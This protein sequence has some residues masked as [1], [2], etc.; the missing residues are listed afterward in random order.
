MTNR[1]WRALETYG[2]DSKITA[3][4]FR[5]YKFDLSYSTHSDVVQLVDQVIAIDAAKFGDGDDLRQ[6]Q[7]I[8]KRWDHRTNI[9]NR[10]AA[11]AVL[12]GEP[13]LHARTIV[14]GKPQ[15]PTEGQMISALREAM[16][17]LKDHFGRLDP[18]WG[19]V[20]RLRRGKLDLAID[21]GPDIYR[22]VYG[23]PQP[24]GTLT[25]AG[26]DTF[27]MFVTW[28]KKGILAS[29]SIHQ[30]GS[31]TLDQ[32]SPH[33]AD[34]SPLFVAMKTKPVLFTLTELSG[35]VEA[36]YQ[37]GERGTVAVLKH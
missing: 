34:Q 26:G 37:P 13:A 30:F 24:D 6:A 5:A 32:S 11:L 29:E 31:A 19:E 14:N 22:A 9:A 2:A 28:D 25:G 7:E 36:D 1:A 21:G 3:A 15:P 4:T 8:L 33:Y 12:L 10:S 17:T 16:K 27:I 20:N 23:L 35:H 18:E